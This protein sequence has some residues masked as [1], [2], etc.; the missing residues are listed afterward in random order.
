MRPGTPGFY[1]GRLKEAREARSVSQTALADLLGITRQA[2]SGYE[3]GL[4][5]PSPQIMRRISE[6]LRVPPHYFLAPPAS[7]SSEAV[8]YRSMES[9]TKAD[10]LRAERRYAWLRRIVQ[11][12]RGLVAFPEVN[13][14]KLDLPSDPT[15][16]T[17]QMVEEAA[18]ETRRFWQLGDNP[19]SNIV[20]LIENNGAVIS[21]HNLE[22]DKLDAFSQWS[23]E[24]NAPYFVFGADKGSGPRSRYDAGHELGHMI[25]HRSVKQHDLGHKPIFKLIEQQANLFTGAFLL[26]E[27]IFAGDL[28]HGVTL[29]ALLALKPKWKVSI[30]FMIMRCETLGIISREQKTRMFI[31][32][33]A[34]GWRLKEPNDDLIPLESPRFLRRSIEML[35][36]K[37]FVDPMEL[38][39][40]VGLD[41]S[42]VEELAGLP[43]G[44]LGGA[45]GQPR[46]PIGQFVETPLAGADRDI[47]P[48]I[49]RFPRAE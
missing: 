17:S 20:W 7:E 33:N 19:I 38:P 25:L 3:S 40:F 30:Q 41:P 14:P 44:Y 47:S 37:S 28:R 42:D 18:R 27:S 43:S 12:L 45:A 16:L 34:R 6:L 5:T 36:D 8:F 46:A 15:H 2:V 23:L 10:R 26:P 24:D 9:A 22:A 1:G 48:K 49:I 11:Y 32:L 29:D 39:F 4:Q 13:F 21:R 35:V 31:N